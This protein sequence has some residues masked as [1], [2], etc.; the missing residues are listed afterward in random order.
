MLRMAELDGAGKHQTPAQPKS[1]TSREDRD[2]QIK[3]SPHQNSKDVDRRKFWVA[4]EAVPE[5]DREANIAGP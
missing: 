3:G 4:C 5:I 2:A 1:R